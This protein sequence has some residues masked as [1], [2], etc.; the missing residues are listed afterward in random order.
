MPRAHLL[1]AAVVAFGSTAAAAPTAVTADVEGRAIPA[2][3]VAEYHCHDFDWPRIHCF[4]TEA[5]LDAAVRPFVGGGGAGNTPA[6]LSLDGEETTTASPATRYVK[7]FQYGAFAGNIAYLSRDYL[8]LDEIGWGDKISSY[9]VYGSASGEFYNNPGWGGAI[10][11][12]CCNQS[13]A[14][15]S[16]IYD[17]QFSAFDLN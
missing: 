8:N 13:M 5:A 7:V 4:R 11:Y 15:L 17:N 2:A 6:T 16:S 9:V 1:L 12:Y 14:A 3:Q 10:D